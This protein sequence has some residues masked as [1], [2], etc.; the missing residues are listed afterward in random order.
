MQRHSVIIIGSGPAGTATALE[1]ARRDPA[2]A[3]DMVVIEKARHPRPKVCAGGLIPH[4]LDCLR[5]L[6]VPL[7]VPNA[8]ANCSRVEI[9]GRTVEYRDD[10]LCRVIRRD[11][12]DASLVA[13]CRQR[14]IRIQEEEKVVEIVRDADGVRVETEAG[15]YSAPLI[16]GADGSGSLV[17]RSLVTEGRDCVGKAI[18]CDVPISGTRWDGFAAKRYDFDFRAVPQGLRGYLWWFPCLIDGVPH[19]NVGV[20]SVVAA[21]AGPLLYRL[22][23][24][25]LERAGASP[26]PIK[27]FPIRWYGRGVRIAAPN[28][29]LAGDAAGVDPLMGEGISYALEYGI[30]AAAA[31][32]ACFQARDFR[33]PAADY[34]RQIDSSWM[35]KK[36][37]RLELT[38]SLFYGR[39][40]RLWFGIAAN[41]PQ[42]QEIG[43]RWYNG[44]DGWDKGSGWSA[45]GAWMRGHYPAARLTSPQRQ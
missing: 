16:I 27:S 43:I 26:T 4:A 34:E 25:E 11:E 8:V 24:E 21:E 44:I 33:Q 45:L 40:W 14:G 10:D 29:L 3:R 35:G 42:A 9:P 37:R 30:R 1:L 22:L 19:A 38:T 7:S 13:A 2:L 18:M 28:V 36:L 31:A 41:S 15:S 39:A 20:Y 17:R 32:Q 5:K 12:F 23:K 6:D